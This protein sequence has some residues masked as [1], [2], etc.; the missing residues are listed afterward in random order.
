MSDSVDNTAPAPCFIIPLRFE[1]ATLSTL[2]EDIAPGC[3]EGWSPSLVLDF[4]R[5]NDTTFRRIPDGLRPHQ[6]EG[7]PAGVNGCC[8]ARHGH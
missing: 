3:A 1:G 7:L 6:S 2:A 8:P 5:L 4:K